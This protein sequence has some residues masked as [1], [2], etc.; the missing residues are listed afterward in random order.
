MLLIAITQAEPLLGAAPHS[1][2]CM[3]WSLGVPEQHGTG[4]RFRR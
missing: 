4:G 3:Y 2:F 1:G